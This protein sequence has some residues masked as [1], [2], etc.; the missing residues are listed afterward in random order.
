[1]SNK[2]FFGPGPSQLYPGIGSFIQDALKED[3]GSISHR[4][5]KYQ[6]VSKFTTDN[7]RKL[8]NLP[9]DYYI[10]FLGSAT[11]AWERIFQNFVDKSSYHFVNGSFSK[12]FFQ[13]AE[14]SNISAQKT[15]V[16]FG[17]GFDDVVNV[18]IP[19][20]TDLIA[21]THNETSSGVSTP[22]EDIY[23]IREKYPNALIAVDVVS[24]LPYPN[25]DFN[26]IDTALFSVQK[27]FGLPA[28]LGVWLVNKRCIDKCLDLQAKGKAIGPHHSLPELI[29]QADV[30]QTPSTPNV[31]AIYLLGRVCDDMLK[32]GVDVLR[33]ETEEKAEKLYHYISKSKTFSIAVEN[34]NHR[35]QT[36]VVA[37][38]TVNPSEINEYLK[39]F[40]LMIG[41][42]Y[43]SYKNSQIRIANFPAHSPEI[44]EKLIEKL[45]EK[46]K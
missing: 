24:S 27:C 22:L 34:P 15:E 20:D 45:K 13:Y 28:G 4:S 16:E 33:K 3:I 19:I 2:V 5:G 37:H 36:V 32:K 11:E 1:M 7:L 9:D 46:Y 25:I 30:N 40:E 6:E 39:P 42:G 38:T 31:L 18:P 44:I 17:F 10:F 14:E 29:K 35:S 23:A 21:F 43:S 12:K 8:I 26:K 41:S